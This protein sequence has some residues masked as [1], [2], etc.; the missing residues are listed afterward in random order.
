MGEQERK[1]NLEQEG[2]KIELFSEIL[3][4]NSLIPLYVV[5]ENWR[6]EESP[7]FLGI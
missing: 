3:F 6:E 1:M 4:Q 5:L 7:C 2:I